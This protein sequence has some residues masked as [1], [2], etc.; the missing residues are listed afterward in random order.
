[1]AKNNY[2]NYTKEQLIAE[3]KKLNKRKKYGLVWEEEKTKEKFE[4]DAEGKLPILVEDKKREIKTEA[5]KPTHILIEGDNYHALSVLNYTH[6]KSIDVIYIDPPYNTGN[7]DFKYN[8]KFVDRE[9]S[10]RHSKWLSFM[11]KRL[12]LAKNLLNESGVIIISID[13]N[14]ITNLKLLCD[15]IFFENNFIALIPTVMNLKGNQ[16]EFGF[17]GT[18]EYTLIYS[19]NNIKSHINEFPIDDEELEKWSEDDISY[20]KKGAPLRATGEESKREDR[21]KMFYPI[22]VDKKTYLITTSITQAEYE[23]IYDSK[24]KKFNDNHLNFLM[25]KYKTKFH[26]VLPI[27]DDNEYG[28][29]RWGWSEINNLKMQTDVIVNT[30]GKSITLYKKQRPEMGEMISKKPKS[31]FYKPEYSSSSATSFLKKMFKGKKVLN[32]PKPVE[33]IKDLLL[34]TTSKKSII[35]DFFA[36]SGTTAHATLK[37]NKEDLGERQIILCT[38]NENN[39]CTEVCYPRV[40]KVIQG[41]KSSKGKRVKGLGGNLKY[42]NTNFVGSE[43]THRNKKL[44]TDKSIEMLCLKEN[45]FDEVISNKDFFIFKSKIRFTAILFNELKIEEF[46]KEIKK[47][48]LPVSIYVFALEGDDFKEEFEGLKND[49]TL[50]SIPEAILKVYRRIYETTKTKK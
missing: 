39:I 36:G 37:L 40:K 23:A 17:A 48:K 42:Y 41:Y 29:W 6:A 14:E 11:S 1:M 8:D 10:F 49:I 16:D 13:D 7:N 25:K 24:R 32:N 20:F 38:N 31:V 27:T 46:K 45:T 18:H 22:L 12:K 30:S 28:R 15:E 33:L 5:D 3:L 9:D 34:L 26:I 4:A 43:P 44:L 35:L 21:E 19:K 2:D 47:L 50:C